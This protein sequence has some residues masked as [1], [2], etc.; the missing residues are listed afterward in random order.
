MRRFIIISMLTL[1][2]PSAFA[3]AYYAQ[4]NYPPPP[5]STYPAPQ[6]ITENNTYTGYPAYAPEDHITQPQVMPQPHP[7]YPQPRPSDYGQSVMTDIR[8]MNF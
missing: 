2:A 3:Q 1:T 4:Q 7:T 8:Q 6:Q 5:N